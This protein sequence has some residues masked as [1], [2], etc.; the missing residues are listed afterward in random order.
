MHSH[1]CTIYTCRVS[2]QISQNVTLLTER[3]SCETSQRVILCHSGWRVTFRYYFVGVG[4][5]SG[6]NNFYS[7]WLQFFLWFWAIFS[8]VPTHLTTG[9]LKIL[10]LP[11][12]NRRLAGAKHNRNS[13]TAGPALLEYT[14]TPLTSSLLPLS[15][16][17][18]CCYWTAL[19]HS[20]R[21]LF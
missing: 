6:A 19:P 13:V 15:C 3:S 2:A 7:L 5:A 21:K 20:L 4:G 1:L 11:W 10:P 16:L 17:Y 9:Q 14:A 12:K 18:I 8:P